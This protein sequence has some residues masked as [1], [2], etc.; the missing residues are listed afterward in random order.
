MKNSVESLG[1]SSTCG[2]PPSS[3]TRD[4]PHRLSA[5]PPN[6]IVPSTPQLAPCISGASQIV[7]RV[8]SESRTFMSLSSA[9]NPSHSPSGEKNGPWAFSA[10]G[11]GVAM[12]ASRWRR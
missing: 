10:P 6:T 4:R 3:E 8:P 2:V 1:R 7:T 11:T 9:T 5:V 12:G